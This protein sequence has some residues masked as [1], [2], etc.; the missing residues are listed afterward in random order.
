M[1][2]HNL[3]SGPLGDN[4]RDDGIPYKREWFWST[5]NVQLLQAFGMMHFTKGRKPGKDAYQIFCT[6][7]PRH[8]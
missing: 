3:I 8:S 1:H 5:N 7:C 4:T 6:L 2:N